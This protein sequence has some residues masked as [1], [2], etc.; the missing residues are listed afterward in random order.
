[1]GWYKQLVNMK[2]QR[3]DSEQK[4]RRVREVRG[5]A[6]WV[7]SQLRREAGYYGEASHRLIYAVTR[8]RLI[9]AM[10]AE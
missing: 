5:D 7:T 2:E 8:K 9:Y 1:M 6:I 3:R 10:I 4:A